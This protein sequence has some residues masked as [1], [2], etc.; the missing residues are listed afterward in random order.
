MVKS[1]A[2]ATWPATREHPSRP[3]PRSCPSIARPRP[4]GHTAQLSIAP[5]QIIDLGPNALLALDTPGLPGET[6]SLTAV[7]TPTGTPSHGRTTL[8]SNGHI[9]Y[10]AP[11]SDP[12]DSFS[13]AVSDQLSDTA[14]GTVNGCFCVHR[15]AEA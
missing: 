13:C 8:M 1:P 14:T 5:G 3:P 7:R 2:P 4:N 9:S 10:T 11:G 6:L 15:A 12:T